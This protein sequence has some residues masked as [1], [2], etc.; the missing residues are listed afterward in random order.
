[1]TILEPDVTFTDYAL[2]AEC[3]VLA[4]LVVRRGAQGPRWRPWFVL[5]FASLGLAAVAGGTVHGFFPDPQAWGSRLLW[6][7]TLLGIGITAVSAWAIGS[8]LLFSEPI[9]RRTITAAWMV[10]SVYTVVVLTGVQ[11]FDVAI[12]HYAPAAVFLFVAFAVR[13]AKTRDPQAGRGTAAVALMIVAALVQYRGV[14]VHPVYFNHNALYHALQGIAL[15]LFYLATKNLHL[16]DAPIP[17][18]AT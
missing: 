13:Y 4:V 15:I 16:L 17:G 10:F 9:M 11:T 5:F 3:A 2:A 7:L 12:A 14:A 6:P 8:G 1:M 18:R